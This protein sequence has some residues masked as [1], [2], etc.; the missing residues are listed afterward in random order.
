MVN[1]KKGI[2]TMA[3]SPA[4]A[5]RLYD[6][7]KP[8][9][10]NDMDKGTISYELNDKDRRKLSPAELDRVYKKRKAEQGASSQKQDNKTVSTSESSS[11]E[12]VPIGLIDKML[13][14]QKEQFEEQV[15][16]LKS[17]LA[18]AQKIPQLLETSRKEEKTNIAEAW[19]SNIQILREQ[20][21][22]QKALYQQELKRS[23]RLFHENKY[24]KATVKDLRLRLEETQST[25][26][27]GMF[28]KKG[29]KKAS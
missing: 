13:R 14:Q 27:F 25:S 12:F 1:V 11:A 26:L 28:S 23:K 19:E 21:G 10:Y 15:N 2:S 5:V 4:E 6:V 3:I 8:T 22:S 16:I 9:L 17:A 7:S 18:E 29:E 24:L 20:V